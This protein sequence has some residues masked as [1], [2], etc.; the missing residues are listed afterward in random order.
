MNVS[1]VSLGDLGRFV[2]GGTPSR[3]IPEYFSGQIPWATVKDFKSDRIASTLEHLSEDGLNNSSARL[4][5]KGSLLIVSRMG[6][7]KVAIAEMDLAINQDIKAFIPNGDH[8]IEFLLWCL[9]AL[10]PE[11]ERLGTGATVKGVTLQDLSSLPIPLPPVEEQHRIVEILNRAASIERLRRQASTHLRDFIPAL[12]LKM[13][14]DPIE[15]PMGWPLSALGEVADVQGGLQVTRKRASNPVER[16]YLRVANVLRDELKLD[17]IKTMRIT[18]KEL[19]RVRLET[20]DLLVVEGHGN[21]NEIGRA[22]IWDGSISDCVHQNHLIRVRSRQE[23]LEPSFAAAFLNSASGRAHLLKSGRTTSGLNTIST[24]DVKQCPVFLPP[25][26]LQQDFA[27]LVEVS[28]ASMAIA[29]DASTLAAALSHSLLDKLLG[30][31]NA[32]NGS[33]QS[34]EEETLTV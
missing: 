29:E 32:A 19:E 4:V 2:G 6:L 12:F 31:Q 34:V 22:A 3:K 5:P 27:K 8:D 10:G 18:E 26:A 15:N 25:L 11:I 23:R 1:L 14:G 28:K 21:P 30:A 20:G 7:G 33:A 13:F 16:P 9:K 24:S 17:E